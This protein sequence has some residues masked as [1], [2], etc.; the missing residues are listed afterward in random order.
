MSALHSCPSLVVCVGQELGDSRHLRTPH[1]WGFLYLPE[2]LLL[3]ELGTTT[4]PH[5]TND[6]LC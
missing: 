4:R 6:G 1:E 3:A 5:M 2:G